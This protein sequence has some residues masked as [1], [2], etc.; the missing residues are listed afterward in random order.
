MAL[1][2]SENAKKEIAAKIGQLPDRRSVLI[3]ALYIA[4]REFQ[5]ISPEVM[6]CLA[7]EL[8]LP[9]SE[10]S[11][12]ATFYTMFNKEPLGKYHIQVCQN[13]TCSLLG[14]E[15]LISYLEKK[16]GIAC[17]QTTADGKF[18]LSRVECL[19]SCGTAPVMQIND[20]YYENLTAE[21]IDEILA[22]L[23][24]EST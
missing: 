12:V 4:Q 22:G 18:S 21:K 19:G 20:D 6:E 2:F 14:A 13:L 3:P 15:S 7:A 5:Y 8:G 1:E 23:G 9:V 10:I 17:G 24:K 16:L 11:G